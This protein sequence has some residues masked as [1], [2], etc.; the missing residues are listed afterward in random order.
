[1]NF[2]TINLFSLITVTFSAAASQPPK[3]TEHPQSLTVQRGAPATLNCA[4]S[5]YPTP[6]ISWYRNGER[7][8]TGAGDHTIILPSGAL[9]FLRTVENHRNQDSGEYTCR[10]ENVHGVVYSES[11]ELTVMCKYLCF[12]TYNYIVAMLTNRLMNGYLDR[13]LLYHDW[14]V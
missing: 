6:T 14:L 13:Y 5:G 8:L 7:V 10:A 2:L 1:M 11:A 4:A 3:I 9:F 12:F